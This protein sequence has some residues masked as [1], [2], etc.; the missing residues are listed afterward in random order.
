M[1][2]VICCVLRT[3]LMRRRISIRLGIGGGGF[4]V[5][6]GKSRLEFLQSV[7]QFPAQAVVEHLLFA[8]LVP[9]CRMRIID[10][11]VKI[12]FE[13]SAALDREIVKV[14]AGGRE[15]DGDLL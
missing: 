2:L 8:D 13:F 6:G 15:N 11:C 7:L 14:T 10:E 9:N 1:A 4:F 12:L 3:D 5:F